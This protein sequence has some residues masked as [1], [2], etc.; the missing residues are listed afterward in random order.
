[1]LGAA[2]P[3][4]PP[5]QAP[6]RSSPGPGGGAS[7]PRRS[8]PACPRRRPLRRPARDQPGGASV[9]LLLVPPLNAGFPQQLAVLFLGHPFTTLLDDGTHNT[10]PRST[11]SHPA[12]RNLTHGYLKHGQSG[13]QRAGPTPIGWAHANATGY[14]PARAR[15]AA[16]TLGGQLAATNDSLRYRL[17]ACSGTRNDRPTRIASSSPE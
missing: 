15:E 11:H 13:M 1:M 5:R 3:F 17:T 14:L 9:A 7:R 8:W 2:S 10:H 16:R 4:P 6:G 12:H